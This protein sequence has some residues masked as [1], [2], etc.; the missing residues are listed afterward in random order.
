MNTVE[1]CLGN[2]TVA[3]AE[4]GFSIRE[5]LERGNKPV[6]QYDLDLLYVEC[7]YCG[8][9]VI[10]EKGKTS[11]LLRGSGIDT[12]LLDAECMI[13]SEGCPQCR[14]GTSLFHL[15]VVRVASFTAQDALLF[16]ADIRG[17]A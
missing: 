5:S 1:Y 15:Y 6:L 3:S 13:L 9:P 4:D 17:N 2:A 12:S 11:L 7:Q 14:P 16:S 8:K 10:W